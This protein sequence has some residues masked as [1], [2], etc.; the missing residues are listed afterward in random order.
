M[1]IFLQ[2]YTESSKPIRAP[3]WRPSRTTSGTR[4]TVWEPLLYREFGK[5]SQP[6]GA[7]RS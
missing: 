2:R 5:I 3:P 6:Q 1:N 7:H 4:N